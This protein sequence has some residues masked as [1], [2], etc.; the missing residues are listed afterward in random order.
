MIDKI[1]FRQPYRCFAK[2]ESYSLQAGVNLLVGDQGTGKSTL[3]QLI[4][5]Y[6]DNSACRES[7]ILPVGAKAKEIIN[8]DTTGQFQI[9]S[10]DFERD[11]PRVKSSID[12]MVD[13]SCR[14]TS[15]GQFVT[16]AHAMMKQKD[17]CLYVM[18]E[19]DMALSIRSC[20]KFIDIINDAVQRGCQLIL[21][22]HNPIIIQKFLVLSLEH[23]MWMPGEEFIQRSMKD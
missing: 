11:N 13:I 15:H 7:A 12:S 5:A 3:I 20:I 4:R 18:D 22:V 19:P 14:Y 6:A 2:D 8:I 17:N 1:T 16:S 23:H 9:F 10:L 21:S